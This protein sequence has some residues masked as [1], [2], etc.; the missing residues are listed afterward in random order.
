MVVLL[1]T[2]S[3]VLLG[4]LGWLAVIRLADVTEDIRAALV[5]V[6]TVVSAGGTLLAAIAALLAARGSRAAARD[7][8]EAAQR[9]ERSLAQHSPPTAK[10]RIERR[11]AGDRVEVLLVV[12]GDD[13]RALTIIE[14][15]WSN[16]SAR[17]VALVEFAASPWE[18]TVPPKTEV[19][20]Q[21][22]TMPADLTDPDLGPQFGFFVI[23][24]DE[25]YPSMTWAAEVGINLMSSMWDDESPSWVERSWE[26]LERVDSRA[27]GLGYPRRAL[28]T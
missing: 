21:F 27:A 18:L 25:G 15:G 16:A 14:L 12:V 28:G 6:A 8:R 10:W 17:G 19:R 22:A 5:A 23:A 3:A 2:A 13:E 24:R 9:A 1:A 7:A 11:P 4:A 20:Q 26:P